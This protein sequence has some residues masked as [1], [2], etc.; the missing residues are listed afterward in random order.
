MSGIHSFFTGYP[1]YQKMFRSFADIPLAELHK[2]KRL[3]AHGYTVM[4][5]LTALVEN[6]DDP[7]VL[8][9]LLH[10]VGRNHGRRKVKVGDFE[11]KQ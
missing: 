2:S 9:E 7:E 1:E 6:L 8:N 5:S 4:T 11:V 10:T 3:I